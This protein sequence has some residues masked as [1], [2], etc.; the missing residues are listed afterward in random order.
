MD[1][2]AI[3]VWTGHETDYAER[4]QGDGKCPATLAVPKRAM[5]L[6][7]HGKIRRVERPIFS[8]YVFIGVKDAAM[9]PELRW[10]VRSTKYFVRILPDTNDPRPIH[11]A[12]RR[13]LSHF[14]S[15]GKVADTSKVIFDEQERIVVIEGPL[16]G[17]EGS[18]VKVDRRKCRAKIRLDMCE[19][20]FLIDLSY[21][22]LER[23]SKG[24]DS[25]HG[26]H[27]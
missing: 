27:D 6:R 25:E 26:Q 7:K 23:P 24:S 5:N 8:G 14:M 12:D 13:I 20:S 18:I 19:D 17:L 3:Q 21:E 16:K 2:Y 15:F 10:M 4:L 11:D 9:A 1:Y 22:V